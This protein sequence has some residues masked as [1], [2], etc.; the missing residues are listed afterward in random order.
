[1]LGHNNCL[2][3]PHYA[4]IGPSITA[5]AAA[6][7]A[8]K[9]RATNLFNYWKRIRALIFPYC[10]DIDIFSPCRLGK[11]CSLPSCSAA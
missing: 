1:M 11:R 5:P 2:Q 9:E 3:K 10:G 4:C 8:T 7:A 6:P